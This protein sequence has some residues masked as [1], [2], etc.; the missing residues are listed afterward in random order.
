MT[1]SKQF[2]LGATLFVL[3]ACQTTPQANMASDVL[4]SDI[5][6][7]SVSGSSATTLLSS[8]NPTCLKFY[9]NTGAFVTMS[10]ADISGAKGPSFGSQLMRTV[11]LG[12]LSGVVGGGVAAMGIDSAFTEAALVG[13][14]N[15][16]TYQAGGAVYDKVVTPDAPNPA[17]P[18]VPALTQMQ[19]IEKAASL[20][21]CPAPDAASIE[22]LKAG[23]AP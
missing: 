11:V 9:E 12:T 7:P 22:A 14:A 5:S 1:F 4:L 2:F 16:V 18:A 10:A 15:Q 20:L 3:A 19:E 23:V 13:T 6:T 21:G 8:S 17:T